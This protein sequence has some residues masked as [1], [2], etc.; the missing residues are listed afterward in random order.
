MKQVIKILTV[1]VMVM[2]LAACATTPG[3]DGY[4]TQLGASLGAGLGAIGGQLVGGSAGA[5]LIGAAVGSLFGAIVGSGVDQEQQ[6]AKDA[7]IKGRT[8]DD[9]ESGGRYAGQA[10]RRT[11][12]RKG[13]D[14]AWEE[15]PFMSGRVNEA[16][17]GDDVFGERP[18]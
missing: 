5:T 11:D 18:R 10:S 2:A 3:D 16:G 9:R 13:T 14:P 8:R 17:E 7:A 12:C 4:N 15:E 6:A 1:F